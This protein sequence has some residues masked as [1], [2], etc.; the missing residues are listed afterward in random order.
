MLTRGDVVERLWA[1][2]LLGMMLSSVVLGDARRAEGK[3]V[4]DARRV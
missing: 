3:G 2:S 1:L 4:R